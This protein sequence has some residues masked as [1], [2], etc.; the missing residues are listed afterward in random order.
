MINAEE[1]GVTSENVDDMAANSDNPEVRRLLGT[2][3]N[4]GEMLGLD[5]KW[6]YNIVKQVGKYG[7]V[8]EKFIGASTPIAPER[9]LH[10]RY[11]TGGIIHAPP[12]RLRRG[13]GDT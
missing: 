3:G 1:Y 2:E 7:E 12:A 6:A 11:Q 13:Q 4:M 5:N 8:F 10:A 9:G